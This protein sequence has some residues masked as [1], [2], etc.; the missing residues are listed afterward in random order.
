MYSWRGRSG[1]REWEEDGRREQGNQPL[2]VLVSICRIFI[3]FFL[4]Y[5]VSQPEFKLS[6]I[7]HDHHQL[8]KHYK[9]PSE[10]EAHI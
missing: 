2:F 5:E 4:D 6:D 1:E 7:S 8:V 10:D 9:Q 3:T